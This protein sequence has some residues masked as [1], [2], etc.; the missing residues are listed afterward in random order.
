MIYFQ[1]DNQTRLEEKIRTNFQQGLQVEHFA[2]KG[3]GVVTTRRFG[4]GEFIVEYKG[5][6]IDKATA[7][8]LE[9]IYPRYWN[10]NT[11]WM[12]ILMHGLATTYSCSQTIS[13]PRIHCEKLHYIWNDQC[14]MVNTITQM[15]QNVSVTMKC[16]FFFYSSAACYMYY[17]KWGP[18]Q[19]EYWWEN[20]AFILMKYNFWPILDFKLFID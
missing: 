18:R 8:Q 10:T 14:P 5:K 19:E 13:P 7:E 15:Y 4:I 2:G 17:F 20:D 12:K 6:V 1:K 16:Y 11:I 9:S 3:R